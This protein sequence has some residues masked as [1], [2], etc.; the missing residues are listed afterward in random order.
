MNRLNGLCT[1]L[2]WIEPSSTGA[3]PFWGSVR[4]DIRAHVAPHERPFALLAWLWLA[5]RILLTSSGFR[6]VLLYRI[7]HAA[8]HRLGWLGRLPAGCCYWLGRHWYGCSMAATAR[9]YGGLVLPHPHGIV[10]GAGVVVGK[11]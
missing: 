1:D 11:L 2:T 7:A 10:V 9:L 5:F 8:R 6:A 3:L 4:A